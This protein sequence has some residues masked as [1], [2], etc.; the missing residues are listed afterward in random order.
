[1]KKKVKKLGNPFS[2]AHSMRGG[3][4]SGSHKNRAYQVEKGESRKVK[5]KGRPHGE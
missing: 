1:M 4:G 3:A 2:L 5:H